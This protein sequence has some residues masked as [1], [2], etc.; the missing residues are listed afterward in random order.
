MPDVDTVPPVLQAAVQQASL[1]SSVSSRSVQLS[2]L[3][4]HQPQIAMWLSI[5]VNGAGQFYNGEWNKGWLMLAP[6]GLY[7]LAWGGDA[8]LQTGYFRTGVFLLGLGV[9][10]YSAWDAYQ[11][12]ASSEQHD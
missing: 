6:W 12:A 5:A 9:K 8:L 1:P 10:V 11:V 7:P 3:P 4:P 2:F